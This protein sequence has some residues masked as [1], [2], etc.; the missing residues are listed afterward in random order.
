MNK[1]IGDLILKE[2]LYILN[3]Y[4]MADGNIMNN[5]IL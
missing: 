5:E 3:I 2:L 4:L 1:M